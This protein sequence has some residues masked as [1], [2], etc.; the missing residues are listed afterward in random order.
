MKAILSISLNPTLQKTLV[1]STMV[2]DTVN[3]A[4][5]HRLD[6]SGKG[7]NVSRVL[8]QLGKKCIH[9]TQLGGTF[10][11]IFLE[12]CLA[13]GLTVEWVESNSP[14]R[15][16]YTLLNREEKTAT[17]LIE[18]GEQVDDHTGDRLLGALEKLLPKISTMIISG[19]KAAG[20]SDTLM[21][22]MVRRAKEKNIKVI[23]DIRG[24]DLYE[25]LKWKPDIIKPNLEEFVSTFAYHLAARNETPVNE[26]SIKPVLTEI[27][28]E[29]QNKHGTVIILTR[30]S[31]PI[32]YMEN[33]D[34]L[35]FEIEPCEAM[36]NVGSGDAF[37]AGLAAALEDGKSLRE[38]IS[39]GAR[40]G[41][42]NA[43]LLRPG[44]I[45]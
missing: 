23:L 41:R 19:S 22:E 15:F 26:H 32:W 31:N 30:A 7:I 39:E 21:S 36:N 44:V 5:L 11:N 37:T 17:E 27:C 16:C 33:N 2:P 9:L 28:R 18:E 42:L 40:C 29:L 1:F 34:M 35:D 13:D 8:T 24:K 25:C 4:L 10:R 14:V 3:R 43:A 6:A 45:S 12:L 38:A 20:F